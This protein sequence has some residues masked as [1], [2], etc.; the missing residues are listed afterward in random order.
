MKGKKNTW[1]LRGLA[2]SL[3]PRA[4]I[5][6]SLIMIAQGMTLGYGCIEGGYINIYN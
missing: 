1:N 5:L 2:D 3:H 6:S 4:V